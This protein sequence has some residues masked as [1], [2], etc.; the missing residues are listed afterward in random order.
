MVSTMSFC[1]G[2][3]DGILRV[4]NTGGA[5]TPRGIIRSVE[6]R[7]KVAFGVMP[8]YTDRSAG[9]V[10]DGG[11]VLSIVVISANYWWMNGYRY[12]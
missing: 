7:K 6:T 4:E 10:G 3:Y 5:F 8:Q 2:V 12:L 9:T 1:R 11:A